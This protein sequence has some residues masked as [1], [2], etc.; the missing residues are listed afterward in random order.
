MLIHP[1]RL[2][3]THITWPKY[4]PEGLDYWDQFKKNIRKKNQLQAFL[5]FV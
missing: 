5:A 4:K 2:N 1:S 3:S